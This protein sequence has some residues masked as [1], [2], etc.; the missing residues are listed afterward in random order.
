MGV[1]SVAAFGIGER[2][3]M[4]WLLICV[5]LFFT[6]GLLGLVQA[7]PARTTSNRYQ[8]RM[9]YKI[10]ADLQQRFAFYKE[11][12]GR[13][14]SVGFQP[15]PGRPR[16]ELYGDTLAGELPANGISTLRLERF[17]RTA[18]LVP[19]GYALPTDVEKTV[20][21]RCDLSIT[22]P[23]RQ[24][25]LFNLAR[26]QLK[27]L[28]LI[29]N[30]G[31]DHQRH[32]QI[33]GRLPV[34]ALDV[35]LKDTAEVPIPTI[36]KNT[37][38]KSNKAP[39]V[40]LAVVIA[41][42]AMPQSDVAQPAS[43]P[44]GKEYLDKISPDL[45]TMLAKIPEADL[46]KFM[47]VELVLRDNQLRDALRTSLQNSEAMFITEGSF[48]PIVTGL[49]APSKL[50]VLAQAEEVSTVRLPQPPQPFSQ[51]QLSGIQFIPLGRELGKSP[52]ITPVAF[53]P[54]APRRLIVIGDDFQG[55]QE[56]IGSGLPKNTRLVDLTAELT[57]NFEPLP[58]IDG[59]AKG[60][61]TSLAIQFLR[62]HP[63]DE[64]ILVRINSTSPYQLQYLGESLL[65]RPWMTPAFQTRKDEW[66][67]AGSRI[68]SEKLELRVKRRRLGEDF[69]L[70]ETTKARREEYRKQQNALD[71]RDKEHYKHGLRISEFS[72]ELQKL[73]GTGT[74]CLALQWN[75]GYADLPGS[76]PHI[77][78]LSSEALR[79]A[80]WY[81]AVAQRPGQVWTGLFRDADRD[82]VMEFTINPQVNRPDLAFLGWK[83]YGVDAN[84][85]QQLPENTVVEVI[86]NWFEVHPQPQGET[87]L[88]RKPHDQLH[89]SILKQRD[90]SGKT[91]P[92]DA[93]EVVG[94]TA[95]LPDRVENGT[96]GSHYQSIVRFT[97][98]AGGGRYA[99]RVRGSSLRNTANN[100][101]T[102]QSEIHP[103][104]TL[105][106]VDPAHRALGRVVYESLATPE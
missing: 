24:R 70:D 53:Q 63:Q 88:Y 75:P 95:F 31:Y 10:D 3:V 55:Y 39:L 79:A 62:N 67:E 5:S 6:F 15:A 106:V 51:S 86:L 96:R 32:T 28:G 30:E 29:E 104:I 34:P 77:R 43:A 40:R 74:L 57:S 66:N 99:L 59:Q 54:P 25:E 82:D 97:V 103:K 83:R 94:R 69:N 60:M 7:Q 41:E 49:C 93:F 35:L 80:N 50:T 36:L 100:Q 89:L 42:P 61:S 12:L 68:E 13:L 26:Q 90:P 76:A 48:G 8:V 27:G 105:S 46:N 58:S 18:I 21:V 65:G 98:P 16:E 84:I 4:R 22:G 47:R 52:T 17:L 14:Q 73:K 92:A 2:T 23:D 64:V 33:L 71:I 1:Q 81:Q 78:F 101:N 9:R 45:K 38:I 102:E 56:S 87:D 20:L 37:T 44:A 72:Q 85:Q 19:T 91:L 11:M